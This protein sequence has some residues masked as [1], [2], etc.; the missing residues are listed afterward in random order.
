MIYFMGIDPGLNKTGVGIVGWN[1]GKLSYAGHALVKSNAKA[2][3]IDRLGSIISGVQAELGKYELHSAAVEDVFYSVNAKSALLLGQTRGAILATLIAA[4]LPAVCEFTALQIKQAVVGYGK[5]EKEQVR[6]MV[7]L[8]LNIEMGTKLPM[9]ISDA[10]A[11]AICL[12]Q[13][14]TSRAY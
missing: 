9:D 10:L 8:H 4:K 13:N 3:F 12:A 11:C 5:A 1:G 2:T 7:E 6:K 14:Q